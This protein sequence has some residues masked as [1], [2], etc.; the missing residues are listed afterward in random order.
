MIPPRRHFVLCV[1]LLLAACEPNSPI[2]DD[3]HV[4]GATELMPEEVWRVGSVD[5][6]DAG[7]SHIGGV[8]VDNEGSIYVLE[9]QDRQVRVYDGEGQLIRRI[10]R[11]GEGPGEF[12]SPSLIGL[13]QDTL[14]VADLNLARIILFL[15]TGELLGTVPT[16][17]VWLEP[18]PGLYM[19]VA[20]VQFTR[21]GFA[22]R[23]VRMMS[24]PEIPQD[25][26][27]VPHVALDRSGQVTDTLRFEKWYL[28][29]AEI[30]VGN[31]N[32]SIPP[33]AVLRAIVC[34][35]TGRH[36]R[37]GAPRSSERANRAVHR[38]ALNTGGR[39]SLQQEHSVS[40][41]DVLRRRRGQYR[42]SGSS[43][44]PAKSRR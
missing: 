29:A 9:T 23:I 36:L 3:G 22:S 24:P 38:H 39:H 33:G 5:D 17:P 4:A 44:S 13:R 2:A 42:R 18:A 37:S 41:C 43:P 6:P 32:V 1:L 15:R 12:R 11:E 20:P 26:I 21:D 14:A 30:R 8:A 28:A 27:P 19:M 16:P 34:R 40:P 25:S 31:L 35:R 7:F 10:G